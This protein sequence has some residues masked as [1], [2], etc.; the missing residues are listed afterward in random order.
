MISLGLSLLETKFFTQSQPSIH[1]KKVSD[2]T[3]AVTNDSW[4]NPGVGETGRQKINSTIT[5][6]TVTIINDSEADQFVRCLGLFDQQSKTQTYSSL[7]WKQRKAENPFI[8]FF[9]YIALKKDDYETI[10]PLSQ[11]L[12]GVF[13]SAN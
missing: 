12:P 10:N 1:V 3:T 8:W 5:R 9:H 6:R 4:N 7:Q 2:T 13:L 11:S